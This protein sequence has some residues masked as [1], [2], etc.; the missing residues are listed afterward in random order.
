MRRRLEKK[1]ERD[2]VRYVRSHGEECL[3]FSSPGT[4]GLPDRIIPFGGEM[5]ELTWFV[6]FKRPGK[7]V[8][9]SGAQQFWID[10]LREKGYRVDVFD[11]LD[12]AKAAFDAI[13][14][15]VK[16]SRD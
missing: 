10:L 8:E 13:L 16:L 7:G 6:E 15:R 4:L 2:F 9:P 11:N 5:V 3:K 12:K 1:I 14:R